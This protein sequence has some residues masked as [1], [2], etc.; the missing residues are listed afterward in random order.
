MNLERCNFLRKKIDVTKELV[1]AGVSCGHNKA[2]SN[3]D[4][5]LVETDNLV[6][7]SSSDDKIASVRGNAVGSDWG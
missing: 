5:L 6:S 7:T 1:L 2:Y 4:D 3:F